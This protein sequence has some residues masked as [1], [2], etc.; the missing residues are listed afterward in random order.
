MLKAKIPICKGNRPVINEIDIAPLGNLMFDDRTPAP[1]VKTDRRG[2]ERWDE[3]QWRCAVARALLAVVAKDRALGALVN[4]CS[5]HWPQVGDA[6][7][8]QSVKAV[9][10]C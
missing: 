3:Q 2:C 6:A 4:D 5:W 8:G 9:D 7:T 10:C 1:Q